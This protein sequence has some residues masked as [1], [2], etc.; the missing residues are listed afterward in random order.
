MRSLDDAYYDM[1]KSWDETLGDIHLRP[2][3]AIYVGGRFVLCW[4]FLYVLSVNVCHYI[5][6]G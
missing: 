6:I 1:R 5:S 2:V 3:I 4:G